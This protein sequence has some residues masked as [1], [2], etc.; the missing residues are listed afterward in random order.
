MATDLSR[1]LPPEI[2]EELNFTKIYDEEVADFKLRWN[3]VR[4][5]FPEL[6]PYDVE[7]L[8]SDPVNI[9]L[10]VDAYRDLII[11]ARINSAAKANLVA[12][13]VGADLD[14]LAA[15]YGVIRMA[16]ETD[17]SFRDRLLIE[18]KGR[19]TGGSKY[20]YAAAARRAD[21]RIKAVV[22]YREKLFPVIHIAVLSHENGGIPDLAMLDAVK[23]VVMSDQVRL[24]NDTI[25]VEAAAST[26]TDIEADVWLLPNTTNAVIEA[27]PVTLRKAWADES[28]VG[29]DLEPSWIEARLHVVGVKR[30][31][32]IAPFLT[33]VADPGVAIAL[34]EIKLNFKG[35]DY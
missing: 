33:V 24:V 30:V 29:F 21:V 22:V 27:M 1:L 15:F 6:P 26:V 34:G 18:I 25:V 16:N 31:K 12:F 4:E 35:Y 7:L 20:W 9:L 19:S 5:K 13:A 32:V 23:A 10:E 3:L 28:S 11:R 8:A 2:I 17:D 14:H